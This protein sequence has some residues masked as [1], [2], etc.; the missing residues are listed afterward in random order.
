MRLEVMVEWCGTVLEVRHLADGDAFALGRDFPH[1]LDATVARVSGGEARIRVPRGGGGELLVGATP[2]AIEVD[3]PTRLPPG[4]RARMEVGELS[5][6]LASVEASEAPKRAFLGGLFDREGASGLGGAM[7]LHALAVFIIVAAP[8]QPD[9]LKFVAPDW[10]SRLSEVLWKP[11]APEPVETE[12]AEDT[13]AEAD[14]DA[15]V[16]DAAPETPKKKKTDRP[17]PA[18]IDDARETARAHARRVGR[19]AS[20]A[21]TEGLADVFASGPSPRPRL[22]SNWTRGDVDGGGNPFGPI[23]P[24]PPGAGGF[25]TSADVGPSYT[26]RNPGV[27]SGL[28]PGDGPRHRRVPKQPPARVH[29]GDPLVAPGLEREQVR[30]VIRAKRGQYRACYEKRLQVERD[31]N[32][33]IIMKFVIGAGGEVLTAIV[34]ESTMNDAQVEGCLRRRMLKWRFPKPVGG[35]TV[36][37]RYPFLFKPS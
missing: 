27:P 35:G 28:R 16:A 14:G 21:I 15:P 34:L 6:Y 25:E 30:R 13:P 23:G 22:T 12:V 26:T 9:E 31:L 5:L 29:A 1:D 8:I 37:V 3:Q 2:H 4:G 32:G 33:K 20:S 17:T 7:L 11:E 10:D 19:E 18:G 36:T 24:R